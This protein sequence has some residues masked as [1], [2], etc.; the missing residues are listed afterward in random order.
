[1]SCLCSTDELGPAQ[2]AVVSDV[3]TRVTIRWTAPD[4]PTI[5][6]KASL[7]MRELLF[8]LLVFVD[9]YSFLI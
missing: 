4:I 5:T 6:P 8:D 3:T 9:R 2:G 7:Q 1:M